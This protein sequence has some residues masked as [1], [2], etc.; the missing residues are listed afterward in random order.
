MFL[1]FQVAKLQFLF[2]IT[3]VFFVN[4][5]LVGK[6]FIFAKNLQGMTTHFIVNENIAQN[7]VDIIL[8]MLKSWDL[9]VKVEKSEPRT[10]NTS[11][12]PFSVG[13]WADYDIDDRTLR[14]K[15]WGT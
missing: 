12:F 6:I 13:L 10:K 11:D 3:K 2:H 15:A 7:R 1:F 5:F 9:E 14:S 8:N 4:F